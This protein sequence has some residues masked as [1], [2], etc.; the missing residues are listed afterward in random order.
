[1]ISNIQGSLSVGSKGT[2]VKNLQIFLNSQGIVV[3][4]TGA[5]SPGNETDSF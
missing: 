4:K 3:A 1:M 5:G 2:N